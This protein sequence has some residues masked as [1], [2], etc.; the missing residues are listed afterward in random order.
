MISAVRW[1]KTRWCK[2]VVAK[3]CNAIVGH[4][5][6]SLKLYSLSLY[7]LWFLVRDTSRKKTYGEIINP[8]DDKIINT[9]WYQAFEKLHRNNRK[10][11]N[12]KPRKVF[13][14]SASKLM[15]LCTPQEASG[16]GIKANTNIEVIDYESSRPSSWIP[17]EG[18]NLKKEDTA[19]MKHI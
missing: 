8:N 3:A 11:E 18:A 6:N 12:C 19:N 5:K 9:R 1:D 7:G 4:S 13:V 16:F 10:K 2:Y 15:Q 14:F 17:E